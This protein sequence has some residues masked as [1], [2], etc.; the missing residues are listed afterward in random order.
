MCVA[1]RGDGNRQL[2]QRGED[3]RRE[4]LVQVA[5][6][7]AGITV[8]MT[9]LFW[10]RYPAVM[11]KSDLCQ[12]VLA[13]KVDPFQKTKRANLSCPP[14]AQKGRSAIKFFKYFN[15]GPRENLSPSRRSS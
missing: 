13:G 11:A 10:L 14:Y 4:F 2:R 8:K 7:Y 5:R 6:P 1:D 15:A 12:R 9:G 3:R